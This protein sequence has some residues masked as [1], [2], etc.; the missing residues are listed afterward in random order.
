MRPLWWDVYNWMRDDEEMRPSLRLMVGGLF[1]HLRE[2]EIPPAVAVRLFAPHHRI[3]GSTTRL[4]AFR[5][6]PFSHF[7]KYGLALR[8]REVY[9]FQNNDFGTLLHGILRGY[10]EWVRAAHG[11]DW[12]AAAQ[13]G[14][15][16]I[17]ELLAQIVPQVRSAVLL[18]RASYRHRVERIRRTARQ[19]IR[20]LTAWAAASEFRP[21]GFEVGFGGHDGVRIAEFPL[22]GGMTLS[23]RGQ[24]DRYD[25]SEDGA[26]YIVL[27]YKTGTV[28]LELPEIRH[29][30]KMQLLLYLY[31]VHCLLRDGAPAGMLYAPAA[32]PLI[33]PDIR[34]DD[35]ALQDASA[36]KSKLTGFLIDDMDV[37]RRI[38]ALTEHLCV[39][40]TG[41]NA[42]SKASEK[43]LRVREEFESLLKFLPQLVRETAE[44]ILSG[45]ITAA[46]YRFKQRTAC[47]FCAYRVV[48]GFAPELGD[49]YRDIPNDAQAAM[50][51]ITDAV[52]EEEDTDGE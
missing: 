17:D 26:Y 51:E 11:N 44:E 43:Y 15:E 34:L 45:R 8:E 25:V 50:E 38:D 20:R 32:N 33:E 48:C 19:V 2:T 28:S 3:A 37:I 29:G 35:D 5:A 46:P 52:R 12:S 42:F 22:A 14:E 9:E 30:L 24:I 7:A 31:V 36:K 40:I 6:C 49:G 10:G 4:E 13:E 27:D 41:K 16:K 23:L 21:Q 39:S 47:A 18:S 1:A